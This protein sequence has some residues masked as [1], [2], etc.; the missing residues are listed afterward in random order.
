MGPSLKGKLLVSAAIA[1]VFP[2]FQRRRKERIQAAKDN[3]FEHV[4]IAFNRTRNALDIAT[5]TTSVALLF[6]ITIV[7]LVPDIGI[8]FN[9]QTVLSF[10]I[11]SLVFFICS[12]LYNRYILRESIA[13]NFIGLGPGLENLY[14]RSFL[15]LSPLGMEGIIFLKWGAVKSLNRI[16]STTLRIQTQRRPIW[17]YD[18]FGM[19]EIMLRF[20]TADDATRFENKFNSFFPESTLS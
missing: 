19:N 6:L 18:L 12:F 16:D 11:L 7:V 5:V 2:Y 9:A 1:S 10:L 3:S 14:Q 13:Y 8:K 20:T 4:S 17:L 15:I